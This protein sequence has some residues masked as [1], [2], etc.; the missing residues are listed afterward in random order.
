[1]TPRTPNRAGI[2]YHSVAQI[3]AAIAHFDDLWDGETGRL[4]RRLTDEEQRFIS[5]ERRLCA[6]DY[7]YWTENF[8]WIVDKEQKP[9]RFKRNIAQ[10]ILLQIWSEFEEQARAIHV[11]NLKARRLGVS[12]E[13]EAATQHRFQF[14]PHS[15]CVVASSDPDKS[16]SMAKMID[17]SLQKQPWWLVGQEGRQSK[18][19]LAEF[20]DINTSLTIQAGN[21]FTG[22]ARGATPSVVHLSEL[23]SWVDPESLVDAAL[24]RAIIDHPDVFC[25]LES[26]A[27]GRGNWWH[28]TWEQNKKDWDRGRGR[29][30]PVFLP[31]YIGTDLYPSATD[32]RARPIPADWTPTDRTIRHAERARSYV[33][34][35]PLLFKYLAKGDREWRMPK[36]QMWFHEIEY[37]T[38]LAKKELNLFLSELPADDIEAFQSEA[39]SV[40]G[41]EVIL[42]YRERVREPWGV[43]TML[44]RDIPQ[45]LTVSRRQWDTSKPPITIKT[46]GLLRINETYT[47]QPLIW[48]GFASASDPDFKLFVWEPPQDD[49]VYGQG[50]DT[51]D[52]LGQDGSVIEMLRKGT[53]LSYPAQ[54]AEFQSP[55]IKAFQFWPMTL[56]LACWYSTFNSKVGKRVQIRSAIEC[57]TNGEA[58]QHE[59]QKRGWWNFHPWKRYDNRKQTPDGKVTKLGVFT[60]EWFRSQ[61][62]DYLL[63]L[64]DEE[65][66]DIY[67]PWFIDEMASIERDP[68]EQK[69]QAAYGEHDDRFMALGF[70][71]FSLYVDDITS[72]KGIQRP[73]PPII[74]SPYEN[75]PVDRTVPYATFTP[76]LQSMDVGNRLALPVVR[77]RRGVAPTLG[78]MRRPRSGRGWT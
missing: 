21:Q 64:L 65:S 48:D 62:M 28:R 71:L 37:E 24:Y 4:S 17:F 75:G 61:M 29:V 8:H 10:G 40:V 27:E 63:T 68:D 31:W 42:N 76:G 14:H 36:A 59:M 66:L 57:R 70:I 49:V 33:L 38:A 3:D 22:V 7:R 60:N 45:S 47:L 39:I 34:A 72:R 52:G 12:T 55:Y 6:L 53:P 30:R 26:T 54:V 56:A 78:Q 74:Q 20:K 1:L 11:Q 19:M 2:S 73:P 13:T 15:N 67:S 18:N 69:A 50:V 32:L 44:G 41:Q 9:V 35:N 77:G 43:F 16:V 58:V 25:I 23:A 5:N 51:G 46:T